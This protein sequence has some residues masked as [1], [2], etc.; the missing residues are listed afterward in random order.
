MT[1]P[2]LWCVYFETASLMATMIQ[3]TC[4]DV[5]VICTLYIVNSNPSDAIACGHMYV[6]LSPVPHSKIHIL[7]NIHIEHVSAFHLWLYVWGI[8]L[9]DIDNLSPPPSPVESNISAKPG[10]YC[11][12]SF[13]KEVYPHHINEC[14]LYYIFIIF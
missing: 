5:P 3:C 2:K 7:Y 12:F 1:H 11:V 4:K 13:H 10:P 14:V 6:L 8:P 9:G